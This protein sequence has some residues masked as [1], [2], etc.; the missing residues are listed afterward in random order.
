MA[1]WI[2][3]FRSS[4][5]S[6]S[7][8]AIS[9]LK[10]R[11]LLDKGK[12]DDDL[13]ADAGRRIFLADPDPAR[14][15]TDDVFGEIEPLPPVLAGAAPL[16]K[17]QVRLLFIHPDTLVPDRDRHVLSA[18][19]PVHGAG[20]QDARAGRGRVFFFYFVVEHGFNCR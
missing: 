4:R 12:I 9:T 19:V 6:K 5:S 7:S 10:I 14:M 15:K 16:V 2:S 11:R 18:A 20:Y 17:T 1:R 13:R 3:S 8:S